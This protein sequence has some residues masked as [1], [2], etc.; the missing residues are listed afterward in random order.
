MEQHAFS[1]ASLG[2]YGSA[3]WGIHPKGGRLWLRPARLDEIPALH[4]LTVSE[5][6]PGVGP[7]RAMHDVQLR[8]PDA[9]WVIE[10]AP[11]RGALPVTAGYYGFLPLTAEGLIGL[12]DGSLNRP[13]PP[14]AMIAPAGSKPA[15]LYVWAVVAHGL[16]RAVNPLIKTALVGVYPDVPVY[17][18]SVTKKGLSAARRRGFV[19]LDSSDGFGTLAILPLVSGGQADSHQDLD[20]DQRLETIVASNAEHL[21]M[22]AFIRGATF[23]AEQHCPYRE[24]YDDNDYCATHILGFVDGEPAAVIRI[25]YFG[26]FAKLERLAVL[27][28]FRRTKIK[29]EVVEAAIE[30]GRRKGYTKFYGQ[31]QERLVAFYA[32]FGFRPMQKNAPLVFSDH[33]YVEIEADLAPHPEPIMV[34]TDPYV[35]IRPE[36]RWD[37]AG[38]LERSSVRPATNP[39]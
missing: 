37:A 10:H 15:A 5:I 7:Q 16:T 29:Y 17:T 1:A 30:L 36:G 26:S 28:R 27:A 22:V 12:R 23:G 4:D 25:R 39:H 13:D 32:K 9:I 24:E 21:N 38:V 6:G 14:L 3:H 2:R 33:A 8:N 18:V 34:S 19:P 31:S 35:I 20:P 11:Y